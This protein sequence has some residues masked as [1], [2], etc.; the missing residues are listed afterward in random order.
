M[1]L[2]LPWQ[3]VSLHQTGKI[4]TRDQHPFQTSTSFPPMAANQQCMSRPRPTPPRS[5]SSHFL[6][7]FQAVSC[8]IQT[9]R[10]GLVGGETLASRRSKTQF[11]CSTNKHGWPRSVAAASVER[12]SGCVL[13]QWFVLG[14]SS[15]VVDAVLGEALW[16]S[17]RMR[18]RRVLPRLEGAWARGESVLYRRVTRMP[19]ACVCR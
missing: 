13:P 14:K 11:R 6:P 3:S 15:G 10:R 18:A 12:R 2:F 5:F 9:P 17:A 19:V 4:A 8:A 7:S 16:G 1:C